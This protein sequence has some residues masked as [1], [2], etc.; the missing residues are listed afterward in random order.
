M[1]ETICNLS[2]LLGEYKTG[3]YRDLLVERLNY[4]T[5]NERIEIE[6]ELRAEF[7]RQFKAFKIRHFSIVE[8]N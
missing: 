6:K 2:L 5:E 7:L 4:F 3:F 8:T 1:K